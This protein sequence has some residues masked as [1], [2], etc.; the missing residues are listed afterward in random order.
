M[1]RTYSELERFSTFDERL[2]YLRMG[3]GV[4]NA[5]FGFDRHV[6][7]AFYKSR[8]WK[9]VRDFVVVRDQGCDLGVIG[10]EIHVGLHVHHMNPINLEDIVQHQ[11]YILDPEYLI[12]TT[13]QTHNAIHYGSENPYPKVVTTR[14]P[15]DT[16][17][18]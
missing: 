15:R 4:G 2:D 5:T 10:Y 12:V 13:Q 18:W 3:G 9:S 6:N 16:R 7:Q 8:E 11:D 1:I 14:S 17:L